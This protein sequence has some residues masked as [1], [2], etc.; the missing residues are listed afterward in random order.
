MKGLYTAII[1]PFDNELN[2]DYESLE[3]L[4]EFQIMHKVDGIVVFGTTGEAPTIEEEEF[5]KTLS[6]IKKYKDSI[7]I[8]VG[9]GT[10][11]TKKTIEKTKKC[12]DMGFDKFLIV[13]PY[14][15]KPN[16]KGLYEHFKA[17]LSLGA[18]VIIYEIPSRTGISIPLEVIK[19]L[20]EEFSEN[21]VA[22]KFSNS[23][24]DLLSRIILEVKGINILSGDDN[25][26]LA[27]MSLGA[28]GVISVLSNVFP[29]EIRELVYDALEGDFLKAREIHYRMY[30]LFKLAFIETNPIP[31]KYMA[32]KKNIIKTPKLRLPL[33]ELSESNIKLIDSIL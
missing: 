26:T 24:L 28:N 11:S 31:I 10:N 4:V 16:T 6:F 19:S 8:V 20:K 13:S 12:M 33:S 25:L 22:L 15:N 30:K 29:S 1:T 32:Y 2:I 5:F 18:K 21:F 17:V 14:Y 27:M 9:A 7:D 3:K 23:D